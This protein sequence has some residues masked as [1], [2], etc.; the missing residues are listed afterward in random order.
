MRFCK[1][2]LLMFAIVAIFSAKVL[3]AQESGQ[4][5]EQAQQQEN[6]EEKTKLNLPDV[7]IYGQER[8]VRKAG[9]KLN[10]NQEK[11]NLL[12]LDVEYQSSTLKARPGGDKLMMTNG[13][14]EFGSATS[15][16]MQYGN[17]NAQFL[18]LNHAREF[19]QADYN[20][21]A[22]Y[23][24]SDGQYRNSRFSIANGRTHVGWNARE[25][26]NFA[27]DA[28][29]LYRDYGMHG[30]VLN[31]LSRKVTHAH[32]EF[33]SH[34]DISENSTAD[35]QVQL[36]RF[37]LLNENANNLSDAEEST[38][39]FIADYKQALRK[40]QLNV[41]T[42][43]WNNQLSNINR[44]LNF[45]ILE[46]VLIY[47]LGQSVSINPALAVERVSDYESRVSPGLEI[48]F[49][50]HP[51]LGISAKANRYLKPHLFHDFWQDNHYL[52]ASIPHTMSDIKLNSEMTVQ[53]QIV[54]NLAIRAVVSHKQISDYYYW[55]NDSLTNLFQ[56][57][58]FNDISLSQ[59]IF[60]FHYNVADRVML[61]ADI[62]YTDGSI[63]DE[64]S[65]SDRKEIP[66][67]AKFR[68]PFELRINFNKATVFS[69]Q[70][71]W[72]GPRR[73]SV[74]TDREIDSYVL[75][76]AQFERMLFSHF[77]AYVGGDNLL[78]DEF[79]MWENYPHTG[80]QFYFGIRAKW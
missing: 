38:I 3:T 4:K 68:I 5:K 29:Y 58:R 36:G 32:G 78:D 54:Q 62:M 64:I 6:E 43:F 72:T 69:A 44:N 23:Q 66:Y 74:F 25:N 2:I 60:G 71:L 79:M 55:Q 7:I 15:A 13:N 73:T 47:P 48:V 17:F 11:P 20:V 39:K 80:L 1:Y 35:V 40:I 77:S 21:S 22:L 76:S 45:F 46:S 8:T 41:R 67:L 10:T 14:P 75:L 24:H 70:A 27:F 52:N 65:G 34:W 30:A 50:P 31:D 33:S 51:K 9:S 59:A 12:D 42:K 49:T 53:Y 57:A 26:L 37:E 63:D 19:E 16:N 18:Q 28:E 56:L 61:R